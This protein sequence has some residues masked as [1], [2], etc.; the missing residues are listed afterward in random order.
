L[1]GGCGRRGGQWRSS[2]SFRDVSFYNRRHL[3]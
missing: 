2:G 3:S 1:C